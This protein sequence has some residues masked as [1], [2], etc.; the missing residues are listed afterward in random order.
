MKREPEFP[1]SKLLYIYHLIINNMK[2]LVFCLLGLFSIAVFL[3]AQKTF[4]LYD[5]M[6]FPGKPNLTSE[7]LLPVFLM[8]EAALTKVDPNTDRVVLDMDKIN[9]QA[10]LA[11]NFPHVMVSTD[12]E[13]WFGDSSVDQYEMFSR[14]SS[15]FDVFRA[16]NPDVV[17]GNYGIAPSA[18]CVYRYYDGGQ[19]EDAVLVQKWKTNNQKRWKSIDA[20]DVIMPVV[21]IAEPNITSWVR[22][23]NITVEEIRKYNTDK[24]IIVY[25]WPQYYDKP[26]SPYNREVIDPDIWRQLLEA[27][28]EV[29][30]GAIIWSGTSDKDGNPV[31]WNSTEVQAVWNETKN[32]INAHKEN[33]IEPEPEPEWII[34]E[35][36][37]KTFKLFGAIN[38]SGTPNLD[39]E[40]IHTIRLIP[41]K[42][43]SVGLD[44]AGIYEP[45]LEKIESLAQSLSTGSEFP[46]C[47]TG[48]TWIRDRTSNTEAMIDRYELVSR[49]FKDNNENNPLGFFQVAPS[50]LSGLRTSNSNF[51][52]NLSNWMHGATMP[53]RPLR[54]YA[55]YLVPASYIVD[56]DTIQWKKEFYLTVEEA[57]LNDPQKPIY[58]YFYTDYFNQAA[59]FPDAYKPIKES[60]WMTMLEAA[61]KMC[62][63]VVMIN[64]GTTAWND[65]FGFWTAT[66]KFIENHKDHIE[67]PERW[68][69]EGNIIQNGS[70]EDVIT[71]SSEQTTFGLTCL[72]PLNCQGFFD[73]LSRNDGRTPAAPIVNVPDY[74]WFE[75]GTTQHECR[76]YPVDHKSYSGNRAM[77]IHNVGGNTSNATAATN[78]WMYHNLAQRI[79]LDDTK[80]YEL[81]FYVQR[82]YLYRNLD[83]LV[84]NLY[85][86]VVSSTDAKPQTNHTY[87]EKV[88][89]PD[90][91]A[92]GKISVTFD[93]PAIIA[94]APGKSF[95]TSAIFIALQT[96]WDA[97]ISKTRQAIVYVDDISLVEK[98]NSS[99]KSQVSTAL[100]G[101]EVDG[102]HVCIEN[103]GKA[104]RIYNIAGL[105][106][107]Q[108]NSDAKRVQFTLPYQGIYIVEIGSEKIR[109]LVK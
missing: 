42:D 81:T 35:N 71:P 41:E 83:N 8:Y 79:S 56:D 91:E 10:V 62:D 100:N 103:G 16:K 1:L 58:A 76:L 11:A 66:K 105:L 67:M 34:N 50:N 15:M 108:N 59:N 26:D 36:P 109:I 24:K 32:F 30:D 39:S 99:I 93:L 65:D 28:Y 2:K 40:G 4:G 19:T 29:C 86:G 27:V 31:R 104:V 106:V 95:E 18:L 52:V 73:D 20:G 69:V 80:A 74:V 21:Y 9:E 14:F 63:G 57:K 54:E 47:I 43:I 13:S 94:G 53:T 107:C 102:N 85:V 6:A 17:I 72:A 64:I 88:F 23:L 12:I 51:Y 97:E 75:R 60:T 68:N 98:G 92:W 7:G 22:D 25:I 33:M 90:N 87:Y 78:G 45:D 37:D 96:S 38:Y 48:G 3:S 82:D 55:D 89:L 5:A 61:Y 101:I 46:V 77:A 70:F 44:D 84:D 49:I